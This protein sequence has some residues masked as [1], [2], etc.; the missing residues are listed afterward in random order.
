MAKLVSKTYGEALFELAIEENTAAELMNEIVSLISVLDE[1]KDFEKILT[2]PGIPKGEKLSIVENTFK[3]RMSNSLYGLLMLMVEKDR[4]ANIREVFE[5]YLN[6]V[7]DYLKI[8]VVYVTTPTDLSGA[9][10]AKIEE[11]ILA[12]SKYETLETHYI[13]DET[14]IGGAVIRI[15]DRR[16][17]SSIR[18]KLDGLKR[19]LLQL[20][21][22]QE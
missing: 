15:G 18:T 5:Y 19:Q 14:L 11:K 2:H 4:A 21:F 1:N 12:T 13:L 8:G 20:K 22:A 10:K 7:K 17:D 3:G 16:I 6:E 9:Q